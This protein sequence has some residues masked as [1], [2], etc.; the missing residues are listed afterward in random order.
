MVWIFSPAFAFR[1]CSRNPSIGTAAKGTTLAESTWKLRSGIRASAGYFGFGPQ[2]R[3]EPP[4]ICPDFASAGEAFPVAANQSHQ[5][6][7]LVDRC[8]VILRLAHAVSVADAIH[9]QRLDVR[10]QPV[11]DGIALH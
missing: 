5:L 7:A 2:L 10:L 11:Q 8:N 4:H 6:E 9:Q 1:I 3:K